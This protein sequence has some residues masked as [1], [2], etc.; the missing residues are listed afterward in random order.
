MKFR[1]V[2]VANRGEIAL[3]IMRT[4]HHLGLGTVGVYSD[5]DANA[6]HVQFADRAIRIGGPEA[7]ESYL[8][9]PN[10]LAA[11]KA[12]GAD[13]IH[14]GYGFLAENA[15]FADAVESAGL[16]FIG[17]TAE[18]ITLMGDKGTAR[19]LM[20]E[21]GVPVTPGYS[22]DDQDQETFLAEAQKIGFPVLVKAVA[23]GGGKG[24]SIVEAPEDLP[25]ALRLHGMRVARWLRWRPAS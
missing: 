8:N 23:G 10:L 14:P 12:S 11:A 1:R 22:G 5:A 18:M 19:H 16:V 9:I 25:A 15:E 21:R 2:L 17:P 24:M 13:A 6:P 7:T 4:C 20:N 3:R